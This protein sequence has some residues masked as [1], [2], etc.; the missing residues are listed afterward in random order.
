[1]FIQLRKYFLLFTL[2]ILSACTA[3][4]TS[5]LAGTHGQILL[6]HSWNE[7]E[8]ATLARILNKFNEIY[9]D[10]DVISQAVPANELLSRY[11]QSASSG[12]GPDLFIGPNNWLMPLADQHL[13]QDLRPYAPATEEYLSR[14]VASLTYNEG[15]YGLPLALRPMALYY[16]TQMVTTPPATLDDWL[17]Q[18]ANENPSALNTNFKP[19]FWG[20]QAFGGQLFDEDSRIVLDQ[21]GFAN[22]LSWLKT[23]QD[24][25]GM[26]LSPDEA[27]LRDLFFSGKAAFYTGNPDDL[28][29]A[30]A[31]LGRENVAVAVL[32]AG[33]NGPSGPLLD[34][35]AIY[36]N[37]ATPPPQTETAVLLAKFLTNANQSATLMREIG[38]VP[39]NRTVKVDPRIYPAEAGFAA[40]ARTAV[41]YP[42][43]PQMEPITAGGDDVYKAVLQGVIEPT[44]AAAFSQDINL[45]FGFD[46]TEP[47]ND[48]CTQ[49]GILRIWHP[50]SGRLAAG[51]N[52]LAA[53][54]AIDCPDLLILV[55]QISENE[56]RDLYTQSRID[57]GRYTLP[58]LVLGYSTWLIPFV[59]AQSIQPIT[60]LIS[61]ETRQRYLPSALNTLIIGED[62]YGL[63]YWLQMETLYYNNEL[64][65]DP[66]ATL[67]ELLQQ[68]TSEKS[69]ALP[70]NF[71]E[72]YW[73]ANGYNV[74]LFTEDYR[75][76]L[77]DTGFVDW[78]NWLL[79]AQAAPG[80]FLDE[81]YVLLQT[82]FY[83][84]DAAFLVG[85]TSALG[86]L[87]A[88]MSNDQLRVANLP[89]GPDGEAAPWLQ[90]TA[91]FVTNGIQDTQREL[92]LS[93]V[94]FATN[95][96]NQ[97]D[98][99]TESR[100]VPANINVSTEND[101]VMNNLI[102]QANKA[103]VPPNVPQ[104]TAVH[105]YGN[106]VYLDVLSER[107][108]PQTAVCDFTRTIDRAN[109]F[110]VTPEDLPAG[111]REQN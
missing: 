14:A 46:V 81:N 51:L 55:S 77:A 65:S 25:P 22:W 32:P 3:G 52:K 90:T 9:P 62:L 16:N 44:E 20:I 49:E 64:A 29:A 69:A 74:Q 53:D 59:Q 47:E 13:I 96:A 27:T 98:L 68:A 41:A 100:L 91:F 15:L 92:A 30:R 8:T 84:G 78:L 106:S 89:S 80:I 70:T 71:I 45:A 56:L 39:A 111:C 54:Y 101:P 7:E 21:G 23:A 18:A 50:W 102:Q 107:K 1:M 12:I 33:P 105:Q 103:F 42:N 76:A 97:T 58:D 38:R 61:A 67:D 57:E 36:F 60:T 43:L 6:W 19:A 37:H 31:A 73:G 110:P 40:Q 108:D 93:F 83:S 11:E 86:E 5:T 17:I 95:R 79:Q 35:E 24:S 75:L 85:P 88:S 99:M 28:P 66:P 72:S 34:V 2:L 10:V 87:E 48:Q 4:S 104:I 26:I 94:N 109:N 82:A 63:P